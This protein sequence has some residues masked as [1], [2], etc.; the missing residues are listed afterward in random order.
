MSANGMKGMLMSMWNGRY[1]LRIND[2][3]GNFVDCEIHHSDM[4]IEIQDPDAYFY[5]HDDGTI[6]L[7]HSPATLGK[8]DVTI[9]ESFRSKNEKR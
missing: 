1:F 8:N 4:N 2:L 7:D 9:V 3:N 5:L 6:E